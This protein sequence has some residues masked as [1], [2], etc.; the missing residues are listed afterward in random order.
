VLIGPDVLFD[1]F[2]LSDRGA[3]QC[4][5]DRDQRRLAAYRLLRRFSD[6]DPCDGQAGTRRVP[7]HAGHRDRARLLS[8]PLRHGQRHLLDDPRRS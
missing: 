5:V 6:P 4:R 3:T 7:L 1:N 8:Q 2:D